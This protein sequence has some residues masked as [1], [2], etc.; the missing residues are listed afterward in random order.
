MTKIDY[1]KGKIYK[2]EPLNGEEGEI[3][4]GS[5]TKEYLSQ[6]M[7]AHRGHYKMWK[8]GKR[9]KITSFDLFDKFGI[10]NCS[11]YLLEA[12][13]ASSKDELH[14]REKYH[15]NNLQCVNKNIP[16]R[17]LKEWYDD[18]K[19]I[20]KT[21][22]REHYKTN[23]NSVKQYRESNKERIALYMTEYR[24]KNK[25][26]ITEH[27]KSRLAIYKCCCGS[28]T[29]LCHKSRHNKTKKHIEYCNKVIGEFV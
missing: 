12:F 5:T 16:T 18:N 21:R 24:I 4:I 23:I 13:N 28:E 17:T 1:S 25:D 20:V 11:I 9:S 15:I 7:T 26:A 3:Y 22:T 29:S 2:I 19:E 14:A 10:E 8:E 27:Q 6:R